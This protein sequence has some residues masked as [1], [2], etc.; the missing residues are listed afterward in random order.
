MPCGCSKSKLT[1]SAH[2]KQLE[3]MQTKRERLSKKTVISQSLFV[4]SG[5]D[6]TVEQFEKKKSKKKT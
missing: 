1:S 5:T 4:L 6:I 2:A 3:Q